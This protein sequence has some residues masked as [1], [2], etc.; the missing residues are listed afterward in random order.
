MNYAEFSHAQQPSQ[1]GGTFA[2]LHTHTHTHTQHTHTHT[3]L[4][5]T[6]V[7]VVLSILLLVTKQ[8]VPCF[9]WSQGL[10]CVV[11]YFWVGLGCSE[12]FSF[13]VVVLLARW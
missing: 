12:H 10:G 9:L 13:V 7:V 5:F 6:G 2:A 3:Q 1:D 4:L 8:F 11:V